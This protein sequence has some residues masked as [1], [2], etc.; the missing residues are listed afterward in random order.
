[1]W[2]RTS[3]VLG[4]TGSRGHWH[5]QGGV[6]FPGRTNTPIKGRECEWSAVR[7]AAT[8]TTIRHRLIG[9]SHDRHCRHASGEGE[10]E[11]KNQ[12]DLLHDKL[13]Y[14]MMGGCQDRQR[15]S[16]I[17]ITFWRFHPLMAVCG[18][19]GGIP[20]AHSVEHPTTSV[21]NEG[22]LSPRA[23]AHTQ[24]HNNNVHPPA[25]SAC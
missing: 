17:A 7:T 20:P 5:D 1:M 21:F 22:P 16:V 23:S 6:D 24:A 11:C 2:P 25:L 3:E 10:G 9:M 14:S 18:R 19:G 12:R 8:S 15:P 13:P 4:T